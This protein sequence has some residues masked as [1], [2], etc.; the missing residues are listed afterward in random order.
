MLII[1]FKAALQQIIQH[2]KK[3]NGDLKV[4]TSSFEYF[5]KW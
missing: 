5:L 2:L 4:Y 1:Q 3:V